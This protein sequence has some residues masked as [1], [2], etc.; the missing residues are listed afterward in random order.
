[1]CGFG[2]PVFADAIK[3]HSQNES[4]PEKDKIFVQKWIVNLL[5]NLNSDSGQHDLGSIFKRNAEIHFNDLKM[6]EML[7]EYVVNPEKFIAF[8]SE[9]WG[10]K[11]E[12]NKET[13][14]VIT[15]VN[16]SYCVCRVM[17]QLDVIKS[18][19]ICHCSEGFAEK[20]FSV[21]FNSPVAATVESSILRGDK[22]CIY[23]I[24][25]N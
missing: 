11:V 23:K 19:A 15:N 12:Y 4:E 3:S 25:V 24:I 21:V 13:K 22:N 17:K 8:L 2:L 6:N 16:K 20:M 5:N 18:S 14:T 1:M 7:T 9:N 10:W